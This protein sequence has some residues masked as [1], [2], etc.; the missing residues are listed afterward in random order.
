MRNEEDADSARREPAQDCEQALGVSK[1]EVRGRFVEKDQFRPG[2]QCAGDFNELALMQVEAAHRPSKEANKRR[3]DHRKRLGRKRV[4][5]SAV[6][7]ANC[8][9][10]MRQVNVFSD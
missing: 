8:V 9:A 7:S 6:D 2:A 4:H 3:I 5:L 1:R 10:A